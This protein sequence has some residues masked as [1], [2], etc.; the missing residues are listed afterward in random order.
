MIDEPR[1]RAAMERGRHARELLDDPALAEAF[2]K[3]DAALIEAWR[4]T[5]HRDT[6][7]RES[8]FRAATLLPKVRDALGEMVTNGDLSAATLR[9]LSG[10]RPGIVA[11]MVGR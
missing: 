2:A 1:E 7:A 8:Y 9:A 4:K 3:V 11:R 5:P 6:E 10:E